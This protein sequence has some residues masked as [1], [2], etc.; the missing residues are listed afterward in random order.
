M[1]G[2]TLDRYERGRALAE[3][4]TIEKQGDAWIVPSSS[5]DTSYRVTLNGLGSVGC[6]CPDFRRRGEVCKHIIA[7]AVVATRDLNADATGRP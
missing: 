4:A 1:S 3:G 5:G 2:A 7:A 6:T